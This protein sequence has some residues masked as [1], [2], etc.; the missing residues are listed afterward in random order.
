MLKDTQKKNRNLINIVTTAVVLALLFSLPIWGSPF[1]VLFCTLI[2]MYA[3]LGQMWNLLTG[4]AGLVSLGQ[5]TFVALG[6]FTL[7]IFS[8][9]FG[10]P[11]LPGILIGGLASAVLAAIMCFIFLRMKGMYFAIATWITAEAFKVLFASWQYVGGGTGL[12]ISGARGIGTTTVYYY[13]LVLIVVS[14]IIVVFLLRSKPGLGLIA[15]KGDAGAAE[16]CGLNIFRTRLLCMM[17]AGYITSLAGGVIYMSQVWVS[18]YAAFAISWTVA[19]MFIVVIGGIGTVGGPIV[20]A[21]VYVF[22]NQY[23]A[24]LGGISMAILGVIAVIV[25]IFAPKGIVGTLQEKAGF[26]IFSLRRSSD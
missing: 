18:P 15:M 21:V 6:G 14:I 24:R 19:S 12:F 7:G 23:L 10:M 25:I 17:L 13:S 11:M 9:Y 8:N 3:T 26:E 16:T 20:G 22:L 1:L 5:Q 2:F 4:Y